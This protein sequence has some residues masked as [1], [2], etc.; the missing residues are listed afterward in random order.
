[1]TVPG[2]PRED[3]E[4]NRA[5]WDAA[6]DE[7]QAIQGAQLDE[8]GAAWGV[9]QIPEADLGILGDTRGRDVL[10]LG[11][12]AAQFSIELARRGA[13]PVGL[14]VSQR[15]LDHAG[16]RMDAA[17]VAF[18]L[19]HGSAE[20]VPMVD[21]SVDIVFGDHGAMAFVDPYRWVPE[22]ARLLRDGGLLAFSMFTPF[23]EACW[24]AGSQHPV[25]RLVNSYA[26][27]HRVDL[28]HGDHVEY[29]LPYGEWIRLMVANGLTVEDLVELWPPPQATSTYQGEAGRRWATRWPLEHVWKARRR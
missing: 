2:D 23:A 15:Q 20:S 11:C 12:G 9:W 5:H 1:M 7:Y 24:A 14:D 26:G 3:A 21:N 6:A 28:G 8:H 10:E 25:E 17:G 4:R 29:Q 13:R 19:I 16:L 27:M 18:P 22:V